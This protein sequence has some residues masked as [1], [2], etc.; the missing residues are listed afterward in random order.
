MVWGGSSC[1]RQ[2]VDNSWGTEMRGEF[3]N[4]KIKRDENTRKVLSNVNGGGKS[5]SI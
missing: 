4:C 1:S 5:L 3:I 2:K